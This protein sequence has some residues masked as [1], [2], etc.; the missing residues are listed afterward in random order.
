MSLGTHSKIS[1]TQ[2]IENIG[3]YQ[4]L[5]NLIITYN[6]LQN[7]AHIYISISIYIQFS[8]LFKANLEPTNPED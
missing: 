6:L 2:S 1:Q 3:I 7:V 4:L 5:Q 8:A